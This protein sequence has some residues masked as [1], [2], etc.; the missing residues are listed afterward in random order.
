MRLIIFFCLLQCVCC[1]SHSLYITFQYKFGEVYDIQ[2]NSS[3]ISV[4]SESSTP[5]YY[6]LPPECDGNSIVAKKIPP[7]IVLKYQCSKT[8]TP[9]YDR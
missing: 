5:L 1:L 8:L 6:Y 4:M 7:Y 9:L 3:F 2:T